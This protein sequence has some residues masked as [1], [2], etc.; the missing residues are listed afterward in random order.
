MTRARLAPVRAVAIVIAS[1]LAVFS[2]DPVEEM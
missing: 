1:G 2:I